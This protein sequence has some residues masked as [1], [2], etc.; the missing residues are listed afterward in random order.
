MSAVNRRYDIDWLRVIAIG[1]L[2]LYHATIGFQPWGI[3]IGFIANDKS[4]PALWI[5][6]TMLNVWRIPFL[7]VVSGMGVYFSLQHRSWK[8]LLQE[9]TLRILVPY[10]FGMFCIFPVSVLIWQYYYKWDLTYTWSPGHLWF[11][12]NIFVYVLIFSPL[13]IYLK[14]NEDGRIVRG[15]K[16]VFSNPV[17]LLLVIAV[18]VAEALIVDPA[19]YELYAMKWHGF[20]LGL[21]AFFVGFC[22]MLSGPAFWEM[23]LRGRWMFLLAAAALFTLRI[24]VFGMHTPAYLLA[25]ESTCWILTVFSF[26]HKYLN[27]PRKTLRYLSEAAYPVYIIHMIFLFLASLLIFPLDIATPLKFVLVLACTFAGCFVFYEFVIRRVKV[28]R[29]LFGLRSLPRAALDL[30]LGR[31]GS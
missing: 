24:V 7:F 2:L 10:V 9:R 6:M 22:F 30:P 1:L 27:R 11:L 5:P 28:I 21:L 25:I 29:P 3:M 13:F 18:F 17:G 23:I 16:K 8:Q 14:R 19:P 31:E 20:F 4:W 26:G 15:I 12:G